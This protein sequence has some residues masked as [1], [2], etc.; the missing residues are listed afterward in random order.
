[1]IPKRKITFFIFLPF[2]LMITDLK[3]NGYIYQL[4]ILFGLIDW[5]GKT[6]FGLWA[7]KLNDLV[8]YLGIYYEKFVVNEV[9]GYSISEISFS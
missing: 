1:M 4:D 8:L 7:S 2:V 6:G 9:G 3:R 5:G